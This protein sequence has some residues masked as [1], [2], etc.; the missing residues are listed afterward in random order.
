M[1]AYCKFMEFPRLVYAFF[2]IAEGFVW[3]AIAIYLVRNRNQFEPEKKPWVLLAVPALLAFAISD[4]CEAPRYGQ[5]LPAWLWTNKIIA[6]F[7]IFLSR[8]VYLGASRKQ[9]I[10]KTVLFGLFLLGVA[11]YLMFLF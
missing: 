3:T 4:F 1:L 7:F 8:V 10:A 2:N 9:E 6:G 5:K 11:F